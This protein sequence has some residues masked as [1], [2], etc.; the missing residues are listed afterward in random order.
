M[1][2]GKEQCEGGDAR[3][4]GSEEGSNTSVQ[5]G[6]RLSTLSSVRPRRCA[7]PAV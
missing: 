7:G 4:V 1:E 6:D 5:A 3:R 2:Q